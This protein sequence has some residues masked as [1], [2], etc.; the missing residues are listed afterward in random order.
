[1]IG[2]RTNMDI[3]DSIIYKSGRFV[4]NHGR[5]PKTVYLGQN[6]WFLLEN[7]FNTEFCNYSPAIE[8]KIKKREV[9]GMRIILVENESHLGFGLE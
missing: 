3:L 5:T 1:M 2:R 7:L 6:E 9:C 4:A 8:G